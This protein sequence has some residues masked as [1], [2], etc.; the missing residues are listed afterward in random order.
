MTMIAGCCWYRFQHRILVAEPCH[1]GE[2]NYGK[3]GPNKY[4]AGTNAPMRSMTQNIAT[5][6]IA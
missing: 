3:K 2:Q 4:G 5:A 6:P 1:E